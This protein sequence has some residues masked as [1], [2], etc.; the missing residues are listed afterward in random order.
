MNPPQYEEYVQESQQA[1]QQATQIEGTDSVSIVPQDGQAYACFQP[2][3][4]SEIVSRIDLV[5]NKS[6]YTI[7]RGPQNDFRLKGMKISAPIVCVYM[8]VARS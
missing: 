8:V 3:S 7:G 4:A 6:I 1:T 5:K 2:C